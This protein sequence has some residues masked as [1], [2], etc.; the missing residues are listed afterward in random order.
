[1]FA[2]QAQPA[3]D[4]VAGLLDGAAA[5][6]VLI[7]EIGA[8]RAAA[9]SAAGLAA[10]DPTKIGKIL[11]AAVVTDDVM[12]RVAAEALGDVVPVQVRR[13]LIHELVV[14]ARRVLGLDA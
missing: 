3:A 2:A 13:L 12:D 10:P 9:M 1:M 4:A 5:G 6:H 8:R 11:L 7:D 14:L